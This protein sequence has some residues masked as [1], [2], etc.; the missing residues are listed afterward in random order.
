MVAMYMYTMY[1]YVFTFQGSGDTPRAPP[2]PPPI[3]QDYYQEEPI[4][5]DYEQ[6]VHKFFIIYFIY[7]I[8]ISFRP[9]HKAQDYCTLLLLH[10]HH[11]Q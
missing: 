2:P 3:S 11:Y 5:E 6:M 7:L 10:H 4:E 8:D 1:Y 9:Q